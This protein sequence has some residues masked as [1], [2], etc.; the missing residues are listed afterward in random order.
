MVYS[1]MTSSVLA[2]SSSS[3]GLHWEILASPLPS[4]QVVEVDGGVVH[5]FRGWGLGGQG[6]TLKARSCSEC[7]LLRERR[8]GSF[9]SSLVKMA[10]SLG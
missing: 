1:T 6:W 7:M 3:T 8:S 4:G 10:I 5:S 9:R 2:P